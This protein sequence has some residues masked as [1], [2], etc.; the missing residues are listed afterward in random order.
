MDFS[1]YRPLIELLQPIAYG[2]DWTQ[3]PPEIVTPLIFLLRTGDMSFS[4]LKVLFVA[5]GR[6]GVT[7]LI[8][9]SQALL[10]LAG[11]AGVISNLDRPVNLLAYSLGF[12]TGTVT[13][14]VIDRRIAA[15]HSLVRIISPACG[16]AILNE[17]HQANLGAT[18]FPASG[19]DGAVSVIYSFVPRRLVDEAVQIAKELDPGAILSVVDVR[20]LSGGWRA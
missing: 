19:R 11:I 13:G 6:R 14:M 9:L 20:S 1:A 5:R 18:E 15:G 12:A 2:L 8:A 4:T 7:W 17:L 3:V 16:A 10:Y